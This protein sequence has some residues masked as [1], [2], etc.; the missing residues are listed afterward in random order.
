MEL[1][2]SEAAAELR[3]LSERTFSLASGAGSRSPSP[4]SA[5]L[6]GQILGS[7]V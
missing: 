7:R 3:G 5:L 2:P 6:V 1:E 4:S